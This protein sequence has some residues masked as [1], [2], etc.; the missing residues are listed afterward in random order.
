MFY[1]NFTED[2]IC[3][4][5]TPW[6]FFAIAVFFVTVI[7]AIYFSRK[8]NDKQ[9]KIMMWTIAILVTSMEIIKIILR[10]CKGSGGDGWIPLYFCSLFIYA[11]WLSLCKNKTVKT[12]G[13]CFMALGGLPA[14][15]CYIFYPST[16]LLL[17]PLWHPASLHSLFYHWLMV[18][19]G[20]LIFI[21]K[22]YKLK[23]LDFVYY[24][25][26]VTIFSAIA[27]IINYI[28]GTN[29]MFMGSPFGLAFLEPIFNYSKELYIILVYLAQAV[30]FYFLTYGIY[31][32]IKLVVDKRR[33][34]HEP[35]WLLFHKQ[36]IFTC[37]FAG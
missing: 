33:I 3:G 24:F 13:L 1:D 35:I 8:L 15:L 7:L 20:S 36:S 9:T 23:L 28:L 27:I 19:A 29:L 16:S 4:I 22:L 5:F 37:R 21:K 14:A 32:I 30:A 12:T 10:L 25:V 31:R 6:H 17:Y 11:I 26:F 2:Q 34:K 18:Y